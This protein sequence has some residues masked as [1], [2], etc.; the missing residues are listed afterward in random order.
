VGTEMDGTGL[1]WC[2][3]MCFCISSV[4]RLGTNTR[5]LLSGIHFMPVTVSER[6]KA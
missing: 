4:E 1:G 6:S 5:N 3:V 2:S